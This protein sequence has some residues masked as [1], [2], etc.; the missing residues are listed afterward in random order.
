MTRPS[1]LA[2]RLVSVAFVVALVLPGLAMTAGVRPAALE[3]RRVAT[4]PRLDA[5]SLG[6][7]AT[8]AA[9]DR[10]LADRFPARNQAVGA[11]AAID[12]GLLGGS[13]TPNV[14]VGRDGWLF[15]R[16]ELEP[17][18]TFTPDQVLAALDR[19]AAALSE[20]GLD[21]RLIV[22]PDKHTIYRDEVVPGSG[23]GDACTDD[24]RAAMQAGMAARPAHAIELWARIAAERAAHPETPLYFRQDTHWTPL[25][26]VIATRAL[27]EALAH[28]VWDETQMPVEGFA[29]YNTDLSRIMGLPA[30]ERIPRLV[31]RPG[32]DVERTTVSTNVDLKNARDI[33]HYTVD[34]AVAAV[35][36]RTLILYDSYFRTNERRIAPWFRDSV[37]VHASDLEESPELAADLPA[38]D[39][40][41]IERV[42]RSAY[43]VDLEVLLA[44]IIAAAR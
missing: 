15:T 27:V 7:P 1:D 29:S 30:K 32:V 18:C 40:V 17:V 43:D 31:V 8:Y 5:D 41:V 20:R 22:P 37:W 4:L 24:R 3:A 12:Y 25:G 11:H 42:E 10:W 34:P 21:V 39:H 33:G 9:I 2:D 36:G 35:E 14:V 16:T 19:V 6:E 38:F 26:A 28:G 13:T 44:P 23:L